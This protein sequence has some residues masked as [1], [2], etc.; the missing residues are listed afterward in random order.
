MTRSDIQVIIAD[1]GIGSKS[2]R[3]WD[4]KSESFRMDLL[5]RVFVFNKIKL[6]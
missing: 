4:T 6:E 1:H 2:Y 3:T 5:N